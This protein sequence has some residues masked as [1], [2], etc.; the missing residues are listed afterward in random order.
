MLGD[1]APL[2]RRRQSGRLE[3]SIYHTVPTGESL[4][5]II[6]GSHRARRPLVSQ[7]VEH[8]DGQ[9]VAPVIAMNW[10]RRRGRVSPREAIDHHGPVRPVTADHTI[11]SAL[12]DRHLDSP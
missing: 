9:H 6:A 12:L 4:E 11:L 3:G 2:D 5:R 1:R 8:L 7:Q 10:A